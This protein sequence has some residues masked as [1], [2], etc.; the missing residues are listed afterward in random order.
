MLWHSNGWLWHIARS[1]SL[2]RCLMMLW[3][4]TPLAKQM[5]KSSNVSLATL[6]AFC[7]YSM[8]HKVFPMANIGRQRINKLGWW[9]L[10]RSEMTNVVRRWVSESCRLKPQLKNSGGF[11]LLTPSQMLITSLNSLRHHA[12]QPVNLTIR[13][14][15]REAGVGA[16][17]GKIMRIFLYLP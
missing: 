17:K 15:P 5:F 3:M 8:L 1:R 12:Y 2:N 11:Q 4:A 16:G 7:W 9:R 13:I 14:I 10:W 6:C